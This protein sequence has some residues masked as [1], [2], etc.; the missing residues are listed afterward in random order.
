MSHAT[1]AQQAPMIVPI[2][3]SMP[4]V[5]D[6]PIVMEHT[7][8]YEMS[9]HSPRQWLKNGRVSGRKAGSAYN[10]A[11]TPTLIAKC[12]SSR[13]NTLMA[14][15]SA[16]DHG[17]PW[18]S[19]SESA[20]ESTRLMLAGILLTGSTSVCAWNVPSR[21]SQYKRCPI[22]CYAC[23]VLTKS[24]WLLITR[25][26]WSPEHEP[27]PGASLGRPFDFRVELFEQVQVNKAS[28]CKI[29]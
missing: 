25:F 17:L 2:R 3:R 27:V 16:N 4:V 5:L 9:P 20:K 21:N 10:A 19:L 8:M 14:R 13:R 28:L 7:T 26:A 22:H 11:P 1:T 24:T 18:E 6:A 12:I 29:E 23:L 15:Y